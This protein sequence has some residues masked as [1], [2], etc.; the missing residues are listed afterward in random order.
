M[1]KLKEIWNKVPVGVKVGLFFLGALFFYLISPFN[2]KDN[3]KEKDPIVKVEEPDTSVSD[4]LDETLRKLKDLEDCCKVKDRDDVVV[5]PKPKKPKIT[6]R[7]APAPR[8]RPIEPTPTPKPKI[9]EPRCTDPLVLWSPGAWKFIKDNGGDVNDSYVKSG[10]EEGLASGEFLKKEF[11]RT[12]AGRRALESFA[13]RYGGKVK[14][15]PDWD[16]LPD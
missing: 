16:T 15:L 12:K 10:L 4:K 9:K 3:S 1:T 5:T 6:P 7:P 14:N 8:P 2:Q 13:A 11:P